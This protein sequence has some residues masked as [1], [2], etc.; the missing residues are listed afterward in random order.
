MLWEEGQKQTR[1][2]QLQGYKRTR[3]GEETGGLDD[4]AKVEKLEGHP[5]YIFY[6]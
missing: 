2:N 3:S 4:F 5:S 6:K 1:G